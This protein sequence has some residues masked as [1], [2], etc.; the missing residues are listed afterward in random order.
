MDITQRIQ[1]KKEI[2]MQYKTR[3]AIL[4]LALLFCT[5][6]LAVQ[7][8]SPKPN[9]LFIAI[10]DLRPELGCYGGAQVKSPNLDT[11]ASEGMV[12]NRAYCQIAV[13]GASRASL[14]T[15]VLPTS[16]RFVN[17][18][19]RAD[20]DAPKAKTLPQTF[21]EAGYTTLSNGKIFHHRGDS[22]AKSWTEPAWRPKVK[23]LAALDPATTRKLSK[24]KRGLIYEHPDV[25]D[26]AYA[27]GKIA[28]KTISD[29]RRLKKDGKPF[30]LACGFIR[31]HMPFYAPKKYWDMYDRQKIEV[32]DNQFR[33]ENAPKELRGS[34]EFR[35]YHLGDFKVGSDKWHRM[36]RHGYYASVSYVDKLVGDVLAELK[37]LG[38]AGNTIVVVWGDHGWHLGE[39]N[40]WGKHNTMHLAT[41]VPLIV[42]VPQKTPATTGALVETSDIF[43]TLCDLA[44][45]TV[46]ATVQGRSFKDI[47]DQPAQSFRDV[48]Y[49]RFKQGD[50]VVTPRYSYTSYNGGKTHM[51]YDLMKDPK[52]NRNIADNPEYAKIVT[53]MKASLAK[54]INQAKNANVGESQS[55][56]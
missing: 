2:Q 31:P 42:K 18:L 43:P 23:S 16:K 27:D 25:E 30:F 1:H 50:A 20:E 33:P 19:A 47:L 40:F 35:S 28:A 5:W 13:C 21:K 41:R 8:A 36:M 7:A 39:H 44:G 46:P 52:E 38:L 10:D 4:F 12:F 49:T 15:S 29:L 32:A 55:S 24:R 53:N 45:I 6:H 51:L 34:G 3:Y 48:V 54:R 9:V 17:Y 56:K 11:L 22:E 37:R 26:G 14:M